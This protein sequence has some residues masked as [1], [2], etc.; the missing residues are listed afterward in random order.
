MNPSDDNAGSS[1]F[2]VLHNPTKPFS[3]DDTPHHRLHC[4]TTD[5]GWSDDELQYF[6]RALDSFVWLIRLKQ[7]MVRIGE[8]EGEKIK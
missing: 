4:L 2:L 1:M 8:A 7:F 6:C 3:P 5:F